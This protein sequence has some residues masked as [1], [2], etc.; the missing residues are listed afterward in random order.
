MLV[1]E[2]SGNNLS[3]RKPLFKIIDFDTLRVRHVKTVF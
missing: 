3:F 1:G 2:K